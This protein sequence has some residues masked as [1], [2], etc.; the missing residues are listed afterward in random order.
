MK[1]IPNFG[2]IPW[3]MLLILPCLFL[4]AAYALTPRERKLVE[5]AKATLD[6]A[7]AE[8][9]VGKAELEQAHIETKN[10]N[11][12]ALLAAGSAQRSGERAVIAEKKAKEMHGELVKCESQNSRM[13]EIVDAVSGPWWFPGL[14][15]LKYGIKKSVFSLLVIIAI[16]IVIGILLKI[17]APGV[18][19]AVTKFGGIAINSAKRVLPKRKPKPKD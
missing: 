8:R 1:R 16:V 18:I 2:V 9:A 12:A 17:F 6:E 13:K 19:K 3:L 11:D 4:S 10:A 5:H 15:A 14:N 7:I